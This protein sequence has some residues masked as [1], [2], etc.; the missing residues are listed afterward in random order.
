[1]QVKE[2]IEQLKKFDENQEVIIRFA[3]STKDDIGYV[4]IPKMLDEYGTEIAIYANYE[5]TKEDCNFIGQ[6]DLK[7]L[8]EKA[9]D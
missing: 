9:S 7:E 3:V 8:W 2:L 4:L 1:M 6:K 5:H